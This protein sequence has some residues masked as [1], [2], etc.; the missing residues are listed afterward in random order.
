MKRKK[1]FAI[2]LAALIVIVGGAVLLGMFLV[3]RGLWW[4]ALILWMFLI[5]SGITGVRR[6]VKE[7]KQKTISP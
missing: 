7:G 6:A 1:R 3:S 5:F 2:A 4:I